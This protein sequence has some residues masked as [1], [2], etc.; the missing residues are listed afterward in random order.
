M[1]APR[2]IF[3]R[4]IRDEFV[5]ITSEAVLSELAEV[6]HRPRVQRYRKWTTQQYQEAAYLMRL[7]GIVVEPAEVIGFDRD[8]KDVHVLGAAL[9]GDADF[10]VTGD[11][12]L[13]DLEEFEGTAIVTPARFL[14]ILETTPN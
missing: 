7:N 3:D 13:L 6:L 12:D 5:L 1:G 11:R 2:A 9:A 4:W 8:V 14:A 10:I